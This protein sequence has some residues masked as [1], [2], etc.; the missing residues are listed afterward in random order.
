MKKQTILK[1]GFITTL[2]IAGAN[3]AMAA[4]NLMPSTDLPVGAVASSSGNILGLP[5][6]SNIA[7]AIIG[8]TGV[9]IGSGITF[10]A[11]LFMRSLDIKHEEEREKAFME[12][13]RKEKEYQIKQEVYRDFLKELAGLETFHFKTIEEFQREWTKT[14]IK[15]DLV[16]SEKLR[17]V[18]E[19]LQAELYNIAEKNIKAGTATLSPNYL[20]LREN[21]LDSIREDMGILK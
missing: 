8:V 7:A 12:Q 17:A 5:I 2:T 18:K 21:L 13:N 6:D 19:T 15:V 1:F 20:K 11:T 3:L 16:A 9:L 4:T 14:E 10:M